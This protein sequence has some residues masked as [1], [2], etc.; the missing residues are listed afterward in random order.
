MGS[1]RRSFLKRAVL[2]SAPV[3]ILRSVW[4][5]N[6]RISYRVIAVGGRGRCLNT[7]F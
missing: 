2:G 5:T 1:D 6:D 4:G 7:K 3:L